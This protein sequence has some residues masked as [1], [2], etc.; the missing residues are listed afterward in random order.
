MNYSEAAQKELKHVLERF[1][2]SLVGKDSR[3]DEYVR[4]Y[5][6]HIET[7]LAELDTDLLTEQDVQEAVSR[8]AHENAEGIPPTP[9]YWGPKEENRVLKKFKPA[10]SS[11]WFWFMGIV[12]PIIA[13]VAEAVGGLCYST[14]F[15]D[16]LPTVFHALLILTV[17]WFNL[18]ASRWVAKRKSL[19]L[20]RLGFLGGFALSVAIYYS[21]LFAA[22]TPLA[23]IGFVAI[24][25]FGIGL[26]CF[27]PLSPLLSLF[28]VLR[29]G[30]V[31]QKEAGLS[32]IPRFGKGLI[33]GTLLLLLCS[34]P[35]Y[36]TQRGLV[37]ASSDD[38]QTALKGLR[39]LRRFGDHSVM[40]RYCYS[41]NSLMMD[42]F[43]WLATGG[44]PIRFTQARESYYQV[45]GQAF[46]HRASPTI[47]IGNRR[48]PGEEF[49]WDPELGGDV[50]AGRLKGLS[51]K[52]SRI[53]GTLDVEAATSYM[54]WTLVFENQWHDQREARAQI[55]LPAGAVV[56]RLTLWIDGEPREAAFGGRSQV[57]QAYKRVVQRRRDPVLVTTSGPDRIL[58]QCFPV[59]SNGEMK[60]RIGITS[61]MAITPDMQRHIQLPSFLER[62]FR[63]PA[64]TRHAVWIGDHLQDD[65]TDPELSTTTIRETA[66]S[67]LAATEW[68]SGVIEQRILFQQNAAPVAR[69]LNVVFDSSAAGKSH[70]HAVKTAL[71]TASP[72]TVIQMFV[73]DDVPRKVELSHLSGVKCEG[74]KEN[75]SALRDALLDQEAD[76]VLWVHGPQPWPLGSA[77]AVLQALERNPKAKLFSY[78]MHHGPHRLIE[79]MGSLPNFHAIPT[80][81]GTEEDLRLFLE[82]VTSG[83]SVH[84]E[85]THSMQ[86]PPHAHRTDDHL[87]RLY[88]LDQ[89]KA[90]LSDGNADQSDALE[91]SLQH[92]LVTPVSGA[93]VLET[94]QQYQQAGL[95]PV[96]SADVP[97]VPE[98]TTL[99]LLLMGVLLILLIRKR[100]N[101]MFCY[102]LPGHGRHG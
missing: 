14:G 52:E 10:L 12:L 48:N 27:L 67:V 71:E 88:I 3:K 20:E 98:P 91:L 28:A 37:M 38:A 8:V 15:A 63:I 53:D 5:A 96:D 62:N 54:E 81:N 45:T 84:V 42:P 50:V 59:P 11:N 82:R 83:T 34:A 92:H 39:L 87:L 55:L 60:L 33:T 85:R 76:L 19:S 24:I 69:R 64:K 94:Q 25:Y 36:L 99:M 86:F 74:A 44:N 95:E 70:R 31:L 4:Q 65:L 61:P 80:L 51:L 90:D 93:V 68:E 29:S 89:I 102:V 77:A 101:E 100:G 1:R 47:G 9:G 97:I 17:P 18:M 41:G 7:K 40:N 78:Q 21:L 79:T 23:I 16:P 49:E 46:H 75:A 56:S 22:L 2:A 26:I 66:T 35:T 72:G 30:S 73:A 43:T 6:A 57:K 58:M 13:L 32:S